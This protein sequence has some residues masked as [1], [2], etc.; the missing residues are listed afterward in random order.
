MLRNRLL[1]GVLMGLGLVA[2]ILID[3]WMDGS[4]T[5]DPSDDRPVKGLLF[6]CLVCG[7]MI[8]AH[9]ELAAMAKA[10]AIDLAMPLVTIGSI[11]TCSTPY[12]PARGQPYWGLY[13]CLVIAGTL[14]CLLAYLGLRKG[15]DGVLAAA[16]AGILAVAYLG[17]HSAFIVQ[18]R[19]QWGLWVLLMYLWVIKGADIGAYTLGMLIGRHK[20][21]PT[22]SPGKTWEGLVGA[23]CAGTGVAILF[24]RLCGIINVWLAICFGVCFAVLGQVG[25]LAESVLKRDARIKDASN[26]VPGFGGI[27]DLM[28]S[29]LIPAPWAYLF[30]V[31]A[32]LGR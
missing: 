9:R 13:A 24:A 6:L 31:A 4:I 1:F 32:G 27:L 28:D 23:I 19:L 2:V 29:P 8:P 14:I 21:L 17:L 3:G 30:F 16:G 12:W 25:D 22:I 20:L 7:L 15:P 11:L 5:A 10:K 18:M 26:L